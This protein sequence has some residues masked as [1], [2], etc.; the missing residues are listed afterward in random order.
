MLDPRRWAGA[1]AALPWVLGRGA[2]LGTVC[3]IHAV[4]RPTR[5]AIVDRH[6]S[7]TWWQL[8]RRVDR[9]ARA[10]GEL[11]AGTDDQV[12]LLLRNGREFCETLL[13]C[14]KAGTT[15]AP[16]NTW[17]KR[18]E[19]AALLEDERPAVLVYDTRSAGELEGAVPGGTRVVHVGPDGDALPAS[20][21]YGD[22]LAEHRPLPPPPVARHRGPTR[23]L[24]HTSGTT[25]RPKAAAR[26]T[27]AR[28]A[29]A[30]VGVLATVPFRHDDVI[31][32]PNPLFH[33]FG[34]LVLAVGLATGATL[35]LPDRFDPERAL[36]DLADH[37]ATA[38]SFVPVMLNRMLDLDDPPDVVLAALRVVLVSGS[39]MPRRLR[40]RVRERF[41][42]VLYDLYGSTEAGWVAIAT[43][44]SMAA[45]PDA[46]GH[47]V[48]GVEVELFDDEIH[49]RSAAT[50]EGYATGEETEEREGWLSTGDLGRFDE[51][52][53]LH[54]TGRADDMVVIGGENVYPQAVEEVVAG[55]DG[56]AEAAV[57]GV[58]DEEMGQILAVFVVGSVDEEAV[59]DACREHLPSYAVPRRLEVVDE[60]PRTATGKVLK[61][62]L[63]ERLT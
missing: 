43:P 9:L 1:A 32:V 26:S 23:V 16:M 17:G 11:G 28:G 53:Y 29:S 54:V 62:D 55:V 19:L 15:A 45:A 13:A 5:T 31:Y 33:A 56:V 35:V 37:G 58:E 49:V 38:A 40:D 22:L 47:P 14:Q 10:L 7:L 8:D 51:D 6:G 3:Q 60:L 57:L 4:S 48:P 44:E 39:A 24:I 50:F 27:G 42:D 21:P 2:S 61:R 59:L 34:V 63:A 46:V 20:T 25:G 30:L 18:R 12:A 36:T 41:G 52:G